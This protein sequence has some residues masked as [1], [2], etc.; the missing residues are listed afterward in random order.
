MYE[1]DGEEEATK[2]ENLGLGWPSASLASRPPAA[3]DRPSEI[4]W[5]AH[6]TPGRTPTQPGHLRTPPARPPVGQSFSA[7]GLRAAVEAEAAPARKN[8]GSAP[9]ARLAPCLAAAWPC[10]HRDSLRS[11][12]P[13]QNPTPEV[14][15][16]PL[17][18]LPRT[19]R[20]HHHHPHQPPPTQPHPYHLNHG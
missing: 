16:S 12:A 7:R 20:P 11:Q 6:S 4:L 8:S 15:S 9:A 17:R 3:T 5:R 1:G 10:T 14:E 18:F 13:R 19:H 2:V